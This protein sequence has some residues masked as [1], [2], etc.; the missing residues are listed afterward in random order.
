MDKYTQ[1]V[2]DVH[3]SINNVTKLNESMVWKFVKEHKLVP[4]A[5]WVADM[6]P[7]IEDAA[8]NFM[9][10]KGAWGTFLWKALYYEMIRLT[11][12]NGAQKR[13]PSTD[14]VEF[15]ERH[16]GL[17]EKAQCASQDLAYL[18][19]CLRKK[20]AVIIALRWEWNLTLYEVARIMGISYQA[21]D[22]RLTRALK[23][24]RSFEIINELP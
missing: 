11:R 18:S 17:E 10:S 16:G 24:M 7:A 2:L 15:E 9:P 23:Q 8:L 1:A 19:Q 22:Q 5:D 13:K 12:K 4:Q 21:I 14:T 20:D 3:E 6:L